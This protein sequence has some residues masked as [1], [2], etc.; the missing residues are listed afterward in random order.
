M[1]GNE[2]ATG[3]WKKICKLRSVPYII[4]IWWTVRPKTAKI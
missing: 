2:H 4:K 3:E 1:F